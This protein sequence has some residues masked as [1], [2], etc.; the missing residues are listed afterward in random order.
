LNSGWHAFSCN[1]FEGEEGVDAGGVTREWFL[2]MSRQIFNP[3]YAL[4]RPSSINSNVFQ[5]NPLSSLNPDHL[6]FFEFVGRFIGKAIYDGHLID[7]YFTRS[8]YK[9]I[10]GV[11]PTFADME[12]IDP[13]FYKSLK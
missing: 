12:S 5:P 8:F 9:H 10:L 3:N 2:M 1:Q 7:A 13:E 11:Q 6:A 4:F